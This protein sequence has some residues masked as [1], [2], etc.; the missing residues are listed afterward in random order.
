MTGEERIRKLS[1]QLL[2]ASA[3]L[4]EGG[5]SIV[6]LKIAVAAVTEM[7]E[8]FRVFAPYRDVPKVTWEAERPA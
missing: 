1:D 4:I 7:G 8:A 2:Q 5:P 6:D 3:D